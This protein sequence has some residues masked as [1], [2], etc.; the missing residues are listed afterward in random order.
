M[1]HVSIIDD[2]LVGSYGDKPFSVPVDL[3]LYEELVE[4]AD[5]ANAAPTME[6]Y[7]ACLDTFEGLIQ[8]DYTKVIEHGANGLIHINPATKEFFLCH[9]KKVSNVPMPQALVDRIYDSI[10]QRIDFMPLIKMWTRW[11]RNPILMEKGGTDFSNRF[12]NFVNMKYVHPKLK[13]ELMEEHGLTEEVASR[14]ATMYQM[15]ITQEGLLNGYKVSSE[16]LHKYDTETGEEVDRYKRTFNPNTGEIDSEGLPEN[17]EDRLFQPSMM[18]SGG[19]AFFCE[20]VNGTGLGHFIR[21]GCTHFLSSWDQVDTRDTASCVKGLHV[22]GLKYIAWYSGEIHNVFIDPMHIGAVPDDQDGAI[23]CKQ[24]FVHS[25][26]SG[27]NGS[28]YH[29]STYAAKTDEEW[30]EMRSESI[31]AW[32]KAAKEIVGKATAIID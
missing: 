6:Q 1:I 23:R 2:N 17:V 11:L 32:G 9:N 3:D 26:L 10:D 20:G 14:R 8:V 27:V 31:A 7:N 22:G 21:V 30:A 16:V 25:S 19:D 4:L 18:G 5:V 28:I 24:Y 15:K 29:S 12:F 13:A